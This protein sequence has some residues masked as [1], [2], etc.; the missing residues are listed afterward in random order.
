MCEPRAESTTS[1]Y[2][3]FDNPRSRSNKFKDDKITVE[4]IQAVS[5]LL[6][7]LYEQ[8]RDTSSKEQ[9]SSQARLWDYL[10]TKILG[11]LTT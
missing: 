8:Q 10:D 9:Q 6:E 1:G 2:V 4:S 11:R 3:A 7:S 5:P